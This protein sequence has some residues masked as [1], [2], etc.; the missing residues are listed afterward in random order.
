MR[1]LGHM[2]GTSMDGLDICL[3]EF[4]DNG[5]DFHIIDAV[6]LPYPARITDLILEAYHTPL[7]LIKDL[8]KT[9]TA[10][11]GETLKG[12]MRDRQWVVD[13]VA[14]HGHTIF[15][16]PNR[17]ITYQIGNLPLLCTLVER[18]VVCNFRPPDV[19]LGGQGAPLVPV[20][21]AQLFGQYAFCLNLGGF[22]NI[23]FDD[24][25]NR[26]AYDLGPCNLVLNNL[27]MQVGME[28]DR[29]GLL[30]RSGYILPDLLEALNALPYFSLPPPKS[31]GREWVESEVFPLLDHFHG[32]PVQNLLCTCVEWIAHFIGRDMTQT[33]Q[34][35]IS[36][37]GAFNTFLVERIRAKTGLQ[38]IIPD[39]LII[40]YKEALIFAYLGWLRWHNKINVLASVTGARK[41]HSSGM[42]YVP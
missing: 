2:S 23:S 42:V 26:R 19:A 33:G 37:G 28:Y 27:S 12:V 4:K 1:V 11:L 36:G 40:S 5:D 8:D 32:A 39:K 20:G 17:G 25:G 16:E 24:E 14:G 3:C 7:D 15:H 34:V 22:A 6:T 38:V 41:D 21:D 31:L 30:A 29:D 18:P 13:L 10:W 9:Y 35:L